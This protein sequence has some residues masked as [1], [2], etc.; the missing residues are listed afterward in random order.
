MLV[1]RFRGDKWLHIGGKHI[2][3]AV[4]SVAGVGREAVRTYYRE[5]PDVLNPDKS[6]DNLEGKK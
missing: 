6:D 3:S 4:Q 2:P 5:H 1:I